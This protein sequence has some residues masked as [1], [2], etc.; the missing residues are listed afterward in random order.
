MLEK[1]LID[2]PKK[3]DELLDARGMT[4]PDPGTSR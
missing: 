3:L 4:E 1:G 2:D